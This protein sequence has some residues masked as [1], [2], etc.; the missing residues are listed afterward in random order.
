[1]LGLARVLAGDE[2]ER[3]ARFHFDRDRSRYIVGRGSLR[4]LLGSY[5]GLEPDQVELD[6][7]HNGKP[8]LRGAGLSFNLSHSGPVALYAISGAGEVGID[9]EL[10]GTDL[11]RELIAER[12]FAPA[13]VATLRSLPRSAQA[14]AFLTCWTRK[15]AFIKARGDGLSLALDSFDVSL[16]PDRPPALLRTSWS[17]HEPDRWQLSDISDPAAGFVAAVALQ[18]F[19]Q[20]AVQIVQS[21]TIESITALQEDE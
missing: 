4:I 10:E 3:A 16:H 1:V 14:R 11:A 21:G 6:Y 5:L 2:R 15:E 8:Q 20:G 12:F 19:G 17:E 7:G 9:V 18:K 13:E